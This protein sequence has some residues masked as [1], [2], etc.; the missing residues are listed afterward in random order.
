MNQTNLKAFIETEHN[1][2]VAELYVTPIKTTDGFLVEGTV[3]RDGETLRLGGVV[4]AHNFSAVK[5][6]DRS[7]F[8][9]DP[10]KGL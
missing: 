4:K 10:F 6:W 5:V 3:T 8:F 1:C 7:P 2:Q 9:N